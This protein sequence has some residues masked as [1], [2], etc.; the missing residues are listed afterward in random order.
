MVYLA[1]ALGLFLIH[2]LALVTLL[3]LI[4]ILAEDSG[5]TII[6][7]TVIA[8]LISI[9]E[10]L[11]PLPEVLETLYRYSIF[12]HSDVIHSLSVG[13]STILVLV[14][15]GNLVFMRKEIK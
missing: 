3:K 13:L 10:V 9:A 12:H 15:Y 5:E 2:M 8:L 14:I 11:R 4:A 1:R 6:I 7:S